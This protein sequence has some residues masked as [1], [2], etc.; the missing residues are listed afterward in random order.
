MQDQLR[1]A[2]VTDEELAVI[3]TACAHLVLSLDDSD[4][5]QHVPEL[6]RIAADLANRLAKEFVA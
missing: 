6:R 5:T 3:V 4:L 2:S 1:M